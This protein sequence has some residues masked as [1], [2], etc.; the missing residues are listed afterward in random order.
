MHF[1]RLNGSAIGTL[2]IEGIG[3]YCANGVIDL[4]SKTLLS[5]FV[6]QEGCWK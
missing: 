2:V 1:K 4:A 5:D 3:K 6:F